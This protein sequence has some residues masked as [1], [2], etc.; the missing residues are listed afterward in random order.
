VKKKTYGLLAALFI[1]ATCANFSGVTRLAGYEWFVDRMSA[2][3]KR[4][5]YFFY[6]PVS[7]EVHEN[8]LSRTILASADAGSGE[9]WDL[10]VSRPILRRVPV[11]GASGKALWAVNTMAQ[12]L[13]LKNTCASNV[14]GRFFELLKRGDWDALKECVETITG[15]GGGPPLPQSPQ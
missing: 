11:E 5:V 14:D 8:A 7:S 3:T 1:I 10:S 4:V 2:R 13:E 12:Y 15:E 9:H 6:I